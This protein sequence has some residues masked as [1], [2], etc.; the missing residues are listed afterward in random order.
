MAKKPAAPSTELAPVDESAALAELGDFFDTVSTDGLEE[1]GGDDIKLAAK[2]WNM[3][4]LDPSG[5]AYVKNVF[6]DTVTEETS[7]AVDC[8]FLLTQKSNRWDE[9]DND[10]K[11]TNVLCTSEDLVTGTM[12]DGMQRQCGGCPDTGWFKDDEGKPFRKCG[13]VHTVVAIDLKTEQPFIARFKKTSLKPFRTHVNKH[14]YKKAKSKKTGQMINVPL[15]VYRVR[16]TLKMH[17]GGMYALP[18]LEKGDT[19]SPA[20]ASTM[21]E[22]AKTY[23]EMMS[24]ILK[25]ADATDRKH[26]S[27]NENAD[28]I[29]SD[30]FVE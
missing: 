23:R 8:V 21:H 13:D 18:I 9:Y 10:K 15:F 17:E 30:D 12:H 22:H 2:L 25:S 6:F 14:H 16:I 26:A 3:G 7:E 27:A 11:K 5:N 24:E 1:I 20:D 28:V 19:L 4:G 29:N